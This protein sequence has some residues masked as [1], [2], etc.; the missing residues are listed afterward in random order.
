MLENVSR[1]SDSK[2][3][4]CLETNQVDAECEGWAQE[5]QYKGCNLTNVY[6]SSMGD[7]GLVHTDQR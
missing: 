7:K 1:R 6:A 2:R 5:G 4:L 3:S